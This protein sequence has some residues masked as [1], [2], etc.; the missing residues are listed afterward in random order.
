MPLNSKSA[1]IARSLQGGWR[2]RMLGV[3]LNVGTL[4]RSIAKGYGTPRA[5]KH[6][7]SR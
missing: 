5:R 7:G 4:L 6:E 1:W 3:V 2:V